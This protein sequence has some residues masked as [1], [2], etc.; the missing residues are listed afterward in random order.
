MLLRVLRSRCF[1]LSFAALLLLLGGGV[2]AIQNCHSETTVQSHSHSD[3]VHSHEIPT[4]GLVDSKREGFD[5]QVCIALGFIVLLMFRFTRLHSASLK[6]LDYKFPDLRH[7]FLNLNRTWFLNL[8][9]L[10]LGVIRV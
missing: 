4:S 5:L 7:V 3:H 9:H 6:L 10:Q 2:A 8:T 1:A